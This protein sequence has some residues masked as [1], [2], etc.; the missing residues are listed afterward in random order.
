MRRTIAFLSFVLVF[1]AVAFAQTS[2]TQMGAKC[3]MNKHA[4]ASASC[5]GCCKDDCGKD[6]C[7]NGS[8][9]KCCSGDSAKMC[10]KDKNCGKKCAH[11]GGMGKCCHDGSQQGAARPNAGA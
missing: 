11:N 7:K 9:M 6:C 10:K 4:S 3:P 8:D 5:K 1:A 2:Q